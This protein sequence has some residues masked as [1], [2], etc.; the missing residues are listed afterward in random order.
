MLQRCHTNAAIA[1]PQSFA[2]GEEGQQPNGAHLASKKQNN[3][4]P[5][6]P[7]EKRTR[8]NATI[9]TWNIERPGCSRS[10]V[11]LGAAPQQAESA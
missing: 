9:A 4:G 8:G 1:K 5:Q 11:V 6:L 7:Q 2:S 10:S 3:T